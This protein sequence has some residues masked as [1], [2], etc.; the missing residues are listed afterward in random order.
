MVPLTLTTRKTHS[1]D[2]FNPV[3][4]PDPTGILDKSVN[5]AQTILYEA[6]G[7][8]T[9]AVDVAGLKYLTD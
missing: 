4:P 3:P 7:H 2:P 9:I 5:A 8:L 1:L 6:L